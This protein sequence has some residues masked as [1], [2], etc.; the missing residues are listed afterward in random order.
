[1]ARLDALVGAM[2]AAE[3]PAK[4]DAIAAVVNEL[5][6]T[7]KAMHQHMQEM[8]GHMQEMNSEGSPKQGSATQ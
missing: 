2:N 6:S 3:G 1:M 5:A 7:H 4:V 8:R